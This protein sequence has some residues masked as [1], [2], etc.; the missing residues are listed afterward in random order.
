[1]TNKYLIISIIIIPI[2][3]II[4]FVYIDTECDRITTF[5]KCV[6]FEDHKNN[7][8][9]EHVTKPYGITQEEFNYLESKVNVTD[10]RNIFPTLNHTNGD[11]E[12]TIAILNWHE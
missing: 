8:I 4:S 5:G 3:A 12:K 6:N 9:K 11:I 1:M 7:L 2:I 10:Y